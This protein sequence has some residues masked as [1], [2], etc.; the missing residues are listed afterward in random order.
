MFTSIL[1]S[2]GLD[3]A[4]GALLG[5]A[6]GDALGTTFEFSKQPEVDWRK[7]VT[8]PVMDLVGGGPF[9]LKPGST[10]DDTA[11][12]CCL[13]I[14]LM[15]MGRFDAVDVAQRYS[16]W[17]QVTFD[18]G[19]TTGAALRLY[20]LTGD[21]TTSGREYWERGGRC[22]A[23]N[24][25]LMRTTPIGVFYALRGKR[26]AMF[27]ATLKDAMITHFDPRCLLASLCFNAAIFEA[28]TSEATSE[29]MWQAAWNTLSDGADILT[30]RF[31]ELV[32]H[33]TNAYKQLAKDLELAKADDPNIYSVE[34][35]LQHM[36]GYVR[37][38][39]RLAF[40][41]LMHAPSFANGVRQVVLAGS[42][43]DTNAAITGALLGVLFGAPSIP[44]QWRE[45]VL[46]CKT[47]HGGPFD[48]IYH[49]RQLLSLV[50]EGSR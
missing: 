8:S 18:R 9:S 13:A 38:A 47:R 49:P 39:F 16:D 34:V 30:R 22:A 25:A 20:K 15:T 7:Q 31:P 28:I 48:D 6:V 27:E 14:S 45:Q 32:S 3:R 11:M 21:P 50:E 41:Q 23:A 5:L 1:N 37:V 10:T 35:H 40:Y 36:S 29:S 46:A 19:S 24:G 42:D 17:S 26:E 12:S 44:K 43:S 2:N 33:T 4:R